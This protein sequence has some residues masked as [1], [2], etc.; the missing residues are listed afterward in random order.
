MI[1]LGGHSDIGVPR[2]Q[3]LGAHLE[4]ASVGWLVGRSP[5]LPGE[6]CRVKFLRRKEDQLSTARLSAATKVASSTHWSWT[7]E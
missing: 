2:L 4:L 6:I 3:A 5:T 7:S 1:L